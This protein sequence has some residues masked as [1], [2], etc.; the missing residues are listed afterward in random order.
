MIID[1][2]GIFQYQN[3]A[4]IYDIMVNI[5]KLLRLVFHSISNNVHDFSIYVLLQLIC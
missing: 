2:K 5:M 4:I 1:I 3:I